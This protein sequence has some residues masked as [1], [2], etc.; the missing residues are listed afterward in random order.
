M[1]AKAAIDR[2]GLQ[3]LSLKHSTATSV[4][5][6]DRDVRDYLLASINSR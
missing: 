5:A 3:H 1:R 6:F 4:V 2:K